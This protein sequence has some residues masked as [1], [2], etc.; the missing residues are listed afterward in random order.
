MT[1]NSFTAESLYNDKENY[2]EGK[3]LSVFSMISIGGSFLINVLIVT[4]A[5]VSA[6]VA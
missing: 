6:I 3:Q 1:R 4:Y 5:I 2:Y